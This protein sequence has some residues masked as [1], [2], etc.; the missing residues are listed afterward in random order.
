MESVSHLE[1][2][3][4]RS[5]T[6]FRHQEFVR[7]GVRGVGS[8]LGMNARVRVFGPILIVDATGSGSEFERR[9]IRPG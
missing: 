5:I 7:E 9:P 4:D 6:Q 1:G 8:D 3:T 2:L